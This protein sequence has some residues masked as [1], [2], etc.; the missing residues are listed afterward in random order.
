MPE[1]YLAPSL[2]RFRTSINTRWPGRDHSSDGW[3]GD[4][5]H[6]ARTSDHNPDKSSGVVRAL[7]IDRDG[8]HIPTLIAA[9]IWH[10]ATRYVIY[11]K[12]IYHVD[13]LMKPRQYLGENQHKGHVHTSIEHSKTAEVSKAGWNPVASQWTWPTIQPGAQG[14]AVSQL[15]A[16]LNGH[17]Y[18]LGLDGDYGPGTLAAVKGFQTRSGLRPDGWVGP[19]T[20]HA[21]RTR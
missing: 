13:Q 7:D 12:R 2:A 20:Q 17:G 6:Q 8:L 21:L 19:L 3:I 4:Q 5:A 1:A 9:A 11:W 18:V 14:T 16:Y 10:P 15:Q